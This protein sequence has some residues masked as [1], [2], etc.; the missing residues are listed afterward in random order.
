[1]IDRRTLIALAA[2]SP[3]VATLPARA[4]RI[5]DDGLHKQDWFLNSFL[6]MGPDLAEAA[7]KG[8]GLMVLVEQRGCPYCRELHA[9]NFERREI[10]DYLTAHYE[11]VQLDLW[12]SREVTDFDGEVMGEREL[13]QKWGVIFTPTVIL[14]PASAAGATTREAAEAF[15][16]PGYFK[17]FHFIG[18]M[19]YVA[20][21]QFNQQ[22]FQRF[23]Q[24]K[25]KELEAQGKK[26][27]LW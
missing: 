15:R 8:K 21:E 19:Q 7:A 17:P 3:L 12:G 26:P 5:G 9:V 11:A 10:V 22:P 18:G 14:F 23:L 27:D 16:M 13:A 6:E 2:A 4:A 1:M 24:D 20:E 25:F